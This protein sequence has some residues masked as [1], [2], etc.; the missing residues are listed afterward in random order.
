VIEF[1]IERNGTGV[2]KSG[3]VDVED[4]RALIVTHLG[5]DIGIHVEVSF[6]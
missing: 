4:E 1:L 2:D 5:R 3:L 6:C